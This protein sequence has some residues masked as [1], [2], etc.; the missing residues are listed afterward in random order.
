MIVGNMITKYI[1]LFPH[2]IIILMFYN[3]SDD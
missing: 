3:D 2:I 1:P